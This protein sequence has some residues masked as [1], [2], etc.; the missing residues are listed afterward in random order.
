MKSPAA[1]VRHLDRVNAALKQLVIYDRDVDTKSGSP[2]PGLTAL[3]R[4][5]AYCLTFARSAIAHG[6]VNA[7]FDEVVRLAREHE[8]EGWKVHR[9]QC[10]TCGGH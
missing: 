10:G 7:D 8:E 5:V 6:I 2:N 4:M 1:R 9:E 3:V